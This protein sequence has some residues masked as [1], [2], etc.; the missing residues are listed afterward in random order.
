M[1]IHGAMAALKQLVPGEWDV[2]TWAMFGIAPEEA[3]EA[4]VDAEWVEL[5]RK[6]IE[7]AQGTGE[8]AWV[9]MKV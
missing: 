4:W 8:K 9:V 7:K 1:D 6:W 2:G 5:K 3:G